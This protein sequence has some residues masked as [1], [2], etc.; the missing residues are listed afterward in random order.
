MKNYFSILIITI[1]I[2]F[3]C[4]KSD[5]NPEANTIYEVSTLKTSKSL[6]NIEGDLS[7]VNLDHIISMAADSKGNVYMADWKSNMV[8]KM[9]PNGKILQLKTDKNL[10]IGNIWRLFI[11]S[12]DELFIVTKVISND[13]M[14]YYSKND[15]PIKQVKVKIDDLE[16]NNGHTVLINK[17]SN[18]K[19][20]AFH[21]IKAFEI[22]NARDKIE[23]IKDEVFVN[24]QIVIGNQEEFQKVGNLAFV[25]SNGKIYSLPG[26]NLY[27]YGLN[28]TNSKIYSVDENF[29]LNY[30]ISIFFSTNEKI[31]FNFG[32]GVIPKVKIGNIISMCGDRD[33]NI[34]FMET[35]NNLIRLR[36]ISKDGSV[37]SLAGRS[38][39]GNTD[40][41]KNKASF[42]KIRGMTV[43]ILGNIFIAT[44]DGI[45][46]VSKI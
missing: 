14:F 27:F 8:K 40:G 1:L 30:I 5:I 44:E 36:K 15:E 6:D 32:D 9:S 28:Y 42:D 38:L 45:R 17:K 25:S 34:F 43:D 22:N 23:G 2:S 29:K 11:S 18:G 37:S 31:T 24:D 20:T 13:I 19:I 12:D 33:G 35:I 7:E 46:K 16:E 3:S 21:G 4:N 41:I 26:A 10:E 39:K